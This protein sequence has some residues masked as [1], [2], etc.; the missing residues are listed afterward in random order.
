MFKYLVLKNVKT[1]SD[2]KTYQ[3]FWLAITFLRLSGLL[4]VVF[5]SGKDSGFVYTAIVMLIVN[6][7]D[8]ILL[9]SNP[10]PLHQQRVAL[11]DERLHAERLK[12]A[13]SQL[14]K[15]NLLLVSAY[16]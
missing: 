15:E 13:E 11:T 9:I 1:D 10:K 6:S 8:V 4:L 12:M 2:F 3:L 14:V 16:L 7:I 5:Y